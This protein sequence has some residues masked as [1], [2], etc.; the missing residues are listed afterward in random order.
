MSGDLQVPRNHFPRIIST[1]YLKGNTPFKKRRQLFAGTAV[2]L[3]GSHAAKQKRPMRQA[4]K[5]GERERRALFCAAWAG[6]PWTGLREGRAGSRGVNRV[7]RDWSA[8]HGRTPEECR[9]NRRSDAP[10][11]S[12]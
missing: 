9:S 10:G 3:G 5:R 11:D 7:T 1:A 8:G 4:E 6:A 12:G 2:P